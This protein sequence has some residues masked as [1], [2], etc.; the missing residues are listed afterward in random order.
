MSRGRLLISVPVTK[1]PGRAVQMVPLVLLGDQEGL[2]RMGLI[3]GW[4]LGLCEGGLE[5]E[6]TFLT[7]PKQADVHGSM[8]PCMYM[9]AGSQCKG[10]RGAARYISFSSYRW[11]PVRQSGRLIDANLDLSGRKRQTHFLQRSQARVTR[12]R[13]CCCC[14]FFRADVP[15]P[16]GDDASPGLWLPN[17]STAMSMSERWATR[18]AV[19]PVVLH[20]RNWGRCGTDTR[21]TKYKMTALG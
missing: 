5:A 14:C 16:P 8:T 19:R 6:S 18:V 20:F 2:A 17:A 3:P 9:P 12:A 21:A 13:C 15:P 10:G 7:T 1:R 11:H 4:V